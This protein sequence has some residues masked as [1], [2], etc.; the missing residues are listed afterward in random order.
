[1]FERL[2]GFD[3]GLPSHGDY[4]FVERCVKS[5]ARLAYSAEAVVWHPTRDDAA[6]ILRTQWV[7]CR[8]Y[9]K[10]TTLRREQ[11][12]GLKLRS[13]VPIVQTARGR[14]KAGMPFTL[15]TP[16][17]ADNGVRPTFAQRTLSLPI[18]YLLVPYWRNVAEVA[19]AIDGRRSRSTSL[20]AESHGTP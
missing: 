15:A 13:W 10:R 11:V 3:S 7:R 14:R 9:A 19:G 1:M 6:G 2:G 4:D 16:W 18:V 17:I 5:G 8:A 20:A 12:E